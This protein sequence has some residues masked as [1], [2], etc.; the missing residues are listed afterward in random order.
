MY[1]GIGRVHCPRP[2]PY[3]RFA[4]AHTHTEYL[5][6]T[7]NDCSDGGGVTREWS[8][9]L[10]SSSSSSDGRERRRLAQGSADKSRLRTRIEPNQAEPPARA[11]LSLHKQGR[12]PE[13]RRTLVA[14]W[15]F[16]RSL[17]LGTQK[18]W[19]DDGAGRRPGVA[20]AGRRPVPV[21]GDSGAA[22]VPPPACLYTPPPRTHVHLYG[23]R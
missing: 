16:T 9:R 18:T 8:G 7:P 20:R 15:I 6:L 3:P 12:S 21:L 4:K 2:A 23:L 11:S 17:S 10:C 5:R 19:R 13:R 22:A 1:Y 14:L